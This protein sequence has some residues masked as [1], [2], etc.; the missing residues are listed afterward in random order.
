MKFRDLARRSGK[1]T[2]WPAQWVES[3]GPGASIAPEDGVLEGL[4]RLG[5]RLLLRINVNGQRR[6][7]SLEWD[8]P[9]AVSDVEIVLLASIGAKIRDVGDL[10]VPT[11]LGRGSARH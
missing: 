9:P 10:E 1:V 5:D 4:T 6:T 7:A 2:A 11:R 3:I 8:A